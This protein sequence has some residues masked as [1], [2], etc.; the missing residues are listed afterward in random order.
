MYYEKL[1][2]SIQEA[3]MEKQAAR[4]L[5][6]MFGR[7]KNLTGRTRNSGIQKELNEVHQLQHQNEVNS[8]FNKL[9][10]GNRNALED[11]GVTPEA[12]YAWG[13]EQR[14]SFNKIMEQK[15]ALEHNISTITNA[16]DKHILGRAPLAN[17]ADFYAAELT[18]DAT[19]MGTFRSAMAGDVSQRRITQFFSRIIRDLASGNPSRETMR[20]LTAEDPLIRNMLYG[21]NGTQLFKGDRIFNGSR[22]FINRQLREWQAKFGY[23]GQLPLYSKHGNYSIYR[24]IQSNTQGIRLPDPNTIPIDAFEKLRAAK[25]LGIQDMWDR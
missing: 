1:L 4:F 21:R 11:M 10:Q 14:A 5:K 20:F 6:S 7:S 2:Q 12:Y 3:A 19:A 13:Q 23:N 18:P 16:Q 15:R 24:P 25:L 8:V 17:N 22:A 9:P